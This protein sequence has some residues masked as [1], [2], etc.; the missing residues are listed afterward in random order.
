MGDE[1]K[2]EAKHVEETISEIK[3]GNEFSKEKVRPS[4]VD[5]IFYFSWIACPAGI[6]M[7]P[8]FIYTFN[9]KFQ[10]YLLIH[11]F[12]RNIDLLLHFLYFIKVIKFSGIYVQFHRHQL[13]R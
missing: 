10:K 4:L 7:T 12:I 2:G 6:L 3:R 9:F 11:V 5:G 1:E 8:Q 13:S